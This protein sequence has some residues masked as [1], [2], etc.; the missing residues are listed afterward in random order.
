MA[1]NA[2]HIYDGREAW[3]NW[4]HEHLDTLAQGCDLALP[5]GK[6]DLL[7]RGLRWEVGQP[8]AHSLFIKRYFIPELARLVDE[9]EE[10][11]YDAWEAWEQRERQE[12][13]REAINDAIGFIVDNGL[14][15][16]SAREA[17]SDALRVAD[18]I[19]SERASEPICSL[20]DELS[21]MRSRL[22]AMQ[23]KQFLGLT[24]GTIPALDEA[25]GG[26]QGLTLMTAKSGGGKTTLALQVVRDIL[27]RYE[28]A[29]VLI[30]SLDMKKWRIQDRLLTGC[31]GLPIRI[32][33][34]GSTTEGWTPEEKRRVET[35]FTSLEKLAH[36]I[37]I[38][39][40]DNFTNAS[41]HNII[42]EQASLL[43]AS[44]CEQI[45]TLIDFMQLMPVPPEKRALEIDDFLIDEV[46]KLANASNGPTLVIT[47]ST[48]SAAEVR[49]SNANVKGSNRIV[50]RADCII[51]LAEWNDNELLGYYDINNGGLIARCV[52][53]PNNKSEAAKLLKQIKEAL[54]MRGETPVHID[55]GKGRDGAERASFEV[56]HHYRKSMVTP[57]KAP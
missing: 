12:K 53:P 17:F 8:R 38:L 54:K 25:T 4:A 26:L 41:R 37:R 6:D 3:V 32:V 30:V 44:K 16:D 36:R 13:Y 20:S 43:N 7:H 52:E 22:A 34:S 18:N 24:Q 31:V 50:M 19:L 49:G 33:Q 40:E 48:K 27:E 28:D 15:G 51:T 10:Y 9:D 42:R 14:S 11:I 5:A 29:C 47:E 45:V 1:I 23:G 46:K 21:Q 57:W 39:D 2:P 35:G 56:I 55:I